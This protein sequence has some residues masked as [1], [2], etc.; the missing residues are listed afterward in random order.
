MATAR[1]ISMSATFRAKPEEV[2]RALTDAKEIRK[3]SGQQGKVEAK[4]G[5]KFEMFDGWAQGT[6]LA[7]K[8]GKILSHTW[9]TADWDEDTKH[10]IV[11]YSFSATKSGTKVTLKHLGLPDEKSR[12]EHQGG[13]I[14]FV[15][16]PL[17]QYFGSK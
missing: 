6:V 7:F 9:H 5:G 12:K 10:S 15:F 13:W 1:A 8:S 3:W 14:E 2:F 4:V 11:K 16:E 17:K